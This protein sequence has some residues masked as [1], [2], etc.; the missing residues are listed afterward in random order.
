M[1]RVE[2]MLRLIKLP[3]PPGAL[4][5]GIPL[6]YLTSGEAKMTI[7]GSGSHTHL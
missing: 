4:D 6:I 2:D 5:G 7:F 3:V 1:V